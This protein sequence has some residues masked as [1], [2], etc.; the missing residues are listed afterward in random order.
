MRSSP[1]LVPTRPAGDNSNSPASTAFV[2]SAVAA[3][4]SSVTTIFSSV[5]AGFVPASG[6]SSLAVLYADATFRVPATVTQTIRQVLQTVNTANTNIAVALPVDDTTPTNTEGTQILSQAI[7]PEVTANKVLCEVSIMGSINALSEWSASLFRGTT[8]IQAASQSVP[9]SNRIVTL[10]FN[11]L[12]SP[13][14]TASQTYTVR[15]GPPSTAQTVAING[16]TLGRAFGG[17]A[18]CTLTLTETSTV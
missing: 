1:Q 3:V 5:A 8:C 13:A 6:G 12:D 9:A 11:F 17:T 7:V 15:A 16:N 18:S 14:S 4:G 2:G 10:A